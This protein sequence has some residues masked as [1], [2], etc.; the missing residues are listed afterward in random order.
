MIS[1]M[2]HVNNSRNQGL[3]LSPCGQWDGIDKDYKWTIHGHTD[4]NYATNPDNQKSVSGT[5]V[6]LNGSPVMA[7]NSTQ[8]V[9]TLS[10]TEAEL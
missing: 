8:K 10:V 4:S 9:V 1:T 5:Q 7:K 6:F 3:L 2:H